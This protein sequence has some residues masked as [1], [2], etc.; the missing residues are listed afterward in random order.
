MHRVELRFGD[1]CADIVAH[2]RKNGKIHIPLA[3]GNGSM[4]YVAVMMLD[5]E[6]MLVGRHMHGAMI[7]KRAGDIQLLTKT[8]NNDLATSPADAPGLV[9]LLEC[10]YSYRSNCGKDPLSYVERAMFIGG[11]KRQVFVVRDTIDSFAPYKEWWP[12]PSVYAAITGLGSWMTPGSVDLTSYTD[13]YVAEKIGLHC[14]D[15]EEQYIHVSALKDMKV[16]THK[17]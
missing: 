12:L 15:Q 9:N 11:Q 6:R 5:K 13:D 3:H 16:S 8:R 10:L 4:S 2:F 7:I 17:V 1:D 14:L